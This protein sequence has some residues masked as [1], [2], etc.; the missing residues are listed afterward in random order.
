M[1][2]RGKLI[3]YDKLNCWCDFRMAYGN[4]TGLVIVD[5]VQKATLMFLST[6]DL[7]SSTD[8]Y[9]RTLRSPK[10]QEDVR[11][12]AEDK[13]R[14]PSI[15]QVNCLDPES[16]PKTQPRFTDVPKTNF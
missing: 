7:G 10:R 15:D 9:Q 16:A 2:A 12:E 1:Q 4:E 8:P 14:S 5:I 6:A 13:A 11:R 3:F